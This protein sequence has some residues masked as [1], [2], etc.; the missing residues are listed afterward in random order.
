MT[1]DELR[2]TFPIG[3]QWTSK[4]DDIG[5][6]VFVVAIDMESLSG[7]PIVVRTPAPGR[8]DCYSAEHILNVAE[9]V[10]NP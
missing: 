3:S 8:Y 9:R 4:F 2:T 7:E 10:E 6:D 5:D 1:E